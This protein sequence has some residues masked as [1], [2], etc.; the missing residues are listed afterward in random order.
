MSGRQGKHQVAVRQ[1]PAPAVALLLSGDVFEDYLDTIGTSLNE[2]EFWTEDAGGWVFGYI[3]AL[4]RISIR[5]VIVVWSREVRQPLRRVYAQRNL[6]VWVLPATRSHRV[7]RWVAERLSEP[8]GW[9]ARRL[10]FASRLFRRY[11]ATPPRVLARILRREQCGAMLVQGYESSR[12]D[13]CVLLG[14]WLSVP[15]LGTFQ[16][17][18]PTS[19]QVLRWIRR[20]TV[21]SAAGLLIGSKQEAVDATRRYRLPSGTVIHVPNAIDQHTWRPGNQAAA[22]AAL[23]LPADVPVA[24][25]NGRVEIWEKGLD[26]LVEAWRLVCARRP[27]VDLQ[28]LLLGTG[29]GSARLRHAIAAAGLRGIHWRDEFVLDSNIVRRYLAA[30]DVYVLPSRHE[31]FAVAPME[32]MA[33]G[34]PVV[35]CNAE[36][37]IDLLAGEEEAGGLIVPREDPEAL[38]QALGRLLDDRALA[39]QLGKTARRR[40]EECYSPE[41]IGLVLASALHKVAPDRFSTPPSSR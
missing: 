15:V 41:A 33:C 2:Y 8:T 29:T 21:S 26:V 11:T 10:R 16:G 13:T 36:G 3:E 22:R 6:A 32:A 12:F 24:C 27:N 14:R 4:Y 20:W 9:V 38:A 35:A 5:T 39:A 19:Y 1:E 40:I 30:A 17:G 37:V 34:R 18:L 25:W 7:A 23:N 28:L 31:G